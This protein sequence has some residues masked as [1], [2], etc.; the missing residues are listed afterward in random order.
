VSAKESS[1]AGRSLKS[2]AVMKSLVK[3]NAQSSAAT[4]QNA[5]EVGQGNECGVVF[6]GAVKI[7]W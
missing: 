7:Q 1:S 4:K 2:S 5:D 3:G 6:E